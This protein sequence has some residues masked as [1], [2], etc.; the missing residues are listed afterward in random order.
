[1]LFMLLVKQE[2]IEMVNLNIQNL[3]KYK[4]YITYFYH[5]QMTQNSKGYT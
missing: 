3:L 1:M 2:Y 5:I 4:W